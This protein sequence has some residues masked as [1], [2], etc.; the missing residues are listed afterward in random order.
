MDVSPLR[1]RPP[2]QQ[3]KAR[4]LMYDQCIILL[5]LLLRLVGLGY[6]NITDIMVWVRVCSQLA[7]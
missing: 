2:R 3:R 1:E 7:P 5:G 6:G 4:Y